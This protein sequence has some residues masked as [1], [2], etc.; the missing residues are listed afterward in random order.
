MALTFVYLIVRQLTDSLALLARGDTAKTVEILLLRHEIAILRRQIKRPRRTWA[1]RALITT[2]AGLLPKDRRRHLSVTPGTLL[3]WHRELVKRYWTRPHRRPGRPNTRAEIR[4]L[5]LDMAKDNATWGYRRIHGELAGLGYRLAP[6]TVWLI[7]KRAGVDPA[8]LRSGP[9]W[10]QFLTAQAHTIL[11][12]DFCHVDTLLFTRL[13]I[14]FVV[15]ISTRRVHILGISAHPTGDWVTQAARNLLMDLGERTSQFKFLIRD[16]DTKLTAAFDTVFAAE[17][18]RILRTPTRAP[19]ANSYAERWVGTLRRELLDR[20]LIVHRHQLEAA[21][22]EYVDH[23][24][25]HRPHRSLAQAAPLQALPTMS[26]PDK[27]RV[28]RRDRL[29]G[30][31]SEYSQAA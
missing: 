8:P 31:I 11:A 1:D 20:I 14:L 10:Q 5:V 21:L 13:Y 24:N 26:P 7:L 3:R 27:V 15:E 25:R 22:T 17:G 28:L 29:G 19:R 18:I 12:T 9:T 30:L 6:S 4:R 23:Y 2:L 16:R